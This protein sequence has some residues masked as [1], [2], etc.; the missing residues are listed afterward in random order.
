LLTCGNGGSATD[1][2]HLAEELVGRYKCTRRPLAAVCLSSDGPAL[3]CIANDFGFENVFSRQVEALGR[4][5]DVLVVFTTSG[6]S[7]NVNRALEAAKQVGVTTVALTGETGG[8]SEELADFVVAVPS[9]NGAR[10]QEMHTLV[11]H[12]ICEEC[13]RRC[14]AV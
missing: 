10:V 14:G 1:A 6:K 12:C 2:A 9:T 3:T 5:G 13:E 8:R 7:E 4:E 11:L